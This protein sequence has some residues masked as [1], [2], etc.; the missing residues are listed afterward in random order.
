MKPVEAAYRRTLC[1]GQRSEVHIYDTQNGTVRCV[2]RS[3]TLLLEAPNWAADDTLILNGD[4]G[5]WRLDPR[6]QA[7]V[8]IDTSGVAYLNNDHVLLGEADILASAFDWHIHRIDLRSGAAQRITSD[9]PA[10]PLRRFLHGVSPDG[11]ELA[12]VG[13]EPRG[14]DPWGAANIFTVR[15]DG[16]GQRQLTFGH[17][18]ADGCE[19]A[20]DGRKIYFNTEA[21]SKRAGHAQI[22][23]MATDGSDLEQLTFDERVNWF[24]HIAPAGGL[25]CYLSYPPDTIGHPE[26]RPVEIRL[27]HDGRWD[28]AEPVV[29]ILG[30]QGTIN[31]NSWSPDGRKFAFVSYP[32]ENIS[33][34][35]MTDSSHFKILRR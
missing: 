32:I 4:G 31:V 20:P 5:L 13:I 23:R 8:E 24:P 15:I 11:K 28:R 18:P 12:F 7:L 27:V 22:A 35:G 21:F 34:N 16:N 14:G 3:A 17:S 25:A 1:A 30:G 10:R 9:D 33:R 26:N 19:Y 6:S 29:E 2:Y